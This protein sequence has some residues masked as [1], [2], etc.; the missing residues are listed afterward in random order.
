MNHAYKTEGSDRKHGAPRMV[1]MC[2]C[3]WS[4]P[5]LDG[6]GSESQQI[7]KQ[8]WGDHMKGLEKD[9]SNES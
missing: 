9:E 2:S 6:Q 4:G 1:A 3:G 5:V 7:A 8:Q